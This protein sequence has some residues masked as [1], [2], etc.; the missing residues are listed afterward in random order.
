MVMV[1]PPPTVSSLK[2][3]FLSSQI[4]VLTRP[5]WP[6]RSWRAVNEAAD[7][8]LPTQIVD[9]T[10]MIVALLLQQEGKRVYSSQASRHVA[11]QISDVYAR[12]AERRVAAEGEIDALAVGKELDLVDDDTIEIL[13][14]TW[15]VEKHVGDHP[16]EAERYADTVARLVHLNQERRRLRERVETLRLLKETI[17]PLAKQEVQENL[18]TR[19]GAVEAELEKMRLLLARVAGRVSELPGREEGGTGDG[20]DVDVADLAQTGK[21]AA[22]DEFFRG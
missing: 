12:E 20:G 21:R 9:D 22:V 17:D 6:T 5:L 4:S 8:P 3:D 19:N 2:F 10:S 7:Q 18:V 13:P 16:V 15:P 14:P 1:P 11:D